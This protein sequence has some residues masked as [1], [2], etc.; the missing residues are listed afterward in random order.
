MEES[1]N[2]KIL[3]KDLLSDNEIFR[4][5]VLVSQS[6]KK[7]KAHWIVFDKSFG[8]L[9]Y[10]SGITGEET[11]FSLV[12]LPHLLPQKLAHERCLKN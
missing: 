7:L 1:D 2:V 11:V 6:E 10:L 8:I 5:E 9:N 3:W 4:N 12:H